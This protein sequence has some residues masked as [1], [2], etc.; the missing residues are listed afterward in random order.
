[1]IKI[2]IFYIASF[3]LH[4]LAEKSYSQELTY[5]IVWKD[6]SIGFLQANRSPVNSFYKY[7]INSQVTFK[8]IGSVNME[9]YFENLFSN[10]VLVKG[11]S[12]NFVN[13]KEK[14]SSLIKWDGKTYS[15]VVDEE[16]VEIENNPIKHTISSIYFQEPKGVKQV[17]S[18]RFAV[19]CTL[20]E[21]ETSKY[22]LTLPNGK[23]NY[24]TYENGICSLVE[25]NHSLATF[26][27]KLIE[28]NGKL[29]LK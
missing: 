14:S 10:G 21:I 20:V 26:Y 6:D 2:L 23:K 16:K 3:P 27:F 5:E 29:V 7:I 19:Y 4:F 9:Y 22:E 25:I 15:A 8:F 1:M 17:F 18:E 28:N 13:S 11:L 12:K 24:Y